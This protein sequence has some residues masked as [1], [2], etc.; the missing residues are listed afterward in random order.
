MYIVL[1]TVNM[2]SCLVEKTATIKIVIHLQPMVS[3]RPI[4]RECVGMLK[5]GRYSIGTAG[6]IALFTVQ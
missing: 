2:L 3:F 5:H 1:D 4:M 6:P